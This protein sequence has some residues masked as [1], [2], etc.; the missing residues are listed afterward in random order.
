MITQ[1]CKLLCYNLSDFKN[2]KTQEKCIKIKSLNSIKNHY[3]WLISMKNGSLWYIYFP[4]LSF[5]LGTEEAKV[6]SEIARHVFNIQQYFFD[7]NSKIF[8]EN[9][10]K[11]NNENFW[12]INFEDICNCVIKF[13]I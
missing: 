6:V 4:L 2:L 10:K 7:A 13:F 1:Y 12:Q 9:K 3:I 11:R 8:V 5:C